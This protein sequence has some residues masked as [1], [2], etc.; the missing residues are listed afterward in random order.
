MPS[1]MT[2]QEIIEMLARLTVHRDEEMRRFAFGFVSQRDPHSIIF[3]LIHTASPSKPYTALSS[4][5]SGIATRFYNRTHNLSRR[6]LAKWGRPCWT[7]HCAYSFDCFAPFAARRAPR[8]AAARRLSRRRLRLPSR[9]YAFALS[10]FETL[11]EYV[12][13]FQTDCHQ[14]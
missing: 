7:A 5:A 1:N 3:R 6:T 13:Q 4:T 11:V 8:R 14:C 9:T 2:V 12:K 10:T